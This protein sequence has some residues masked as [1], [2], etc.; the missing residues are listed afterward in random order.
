MTDYSLAKHDK[1]AVRQALLNNIT[2][3]LPDFN[4]TH[5]KPAPTDTR[6]RCVQCD[7]GEHDIV[8]QQPMREGLAVTL[9]HKFVEGLTLE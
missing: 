8:S 5:S 1:L 3:L 7:G 4:C 9:R 2:M 6:W